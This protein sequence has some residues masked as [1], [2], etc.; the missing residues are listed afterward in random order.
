MYMTMYT[1]ISAIDKKHEDVHS[2]FLYIW[3]NIKVSECVLK[4]I[5]YNASGCPTWTYPN[6]SQGECVWQ[7]SGKC[8]CMSYDQV[9]DTTIVGNCPY[10]LPGTEY[11]FVLIP[12]ERSSLS[13]SKDLPLWRV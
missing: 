3:K 12:K 1:V 11:N 13:S 9:L 7:Q 6:S 8:Y 4:H 10:R 2:H 5:K